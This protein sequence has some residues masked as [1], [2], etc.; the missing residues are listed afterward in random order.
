M[1]R[2]MSSKNVVALLLSGI[3]VASMVPVSAFGLDEVPPSVGDD[4][5]SEIV[6]A[7]CPEPEFDEFSGGQAQS[8]RFIDGF[9]D[10]TLMELSELSGV[11]AYSAFGDVK[12]DYRA[13][14]SKVNGRKTYTYRVNPTDKDRLVSVNGVLEVGIDVSEHNNAPGGGAAR[15]INWQKVKADGITFAIIRCGYGSD[16][17]SQDDD[18]FASNYKGAKAAGLKVG[19]YLYSYAKKATG[20]NPS[21]A[22]EADHVLRVFRENGIEPSDLDLPVYYDLEDKGQLGLEKRV[23]GQMATV[24][25]DKLQARGYKVGIYA[26]LDWFNTM[27]TD[28]VFKLENMKAKGWS[29]W[30]ARYPYG[31]ATSGVEG[32]DVWQFTSIGLVSGT[33]KKYCDVNFMFSSNFPNGGSG[34]ASGGNSVPQWVKSGSTWYLRCN[35]KNLTG[36][37]KVGSYWYWMDSS[38]AMRTGWL[39]LGGTWYYLD[40]SGAMATGWKRVGGAWY[41]LNPGSGAMATG[42]KYVDGAWYW[43]DSSGAMRTGWLLLGGTWYY[44]DGS[45]AMATGWKRVGGAWYYLN[46]GSGAMATGWK[47]VDGAWY[48]MDSSGAMRTGWLLIDG[49][50]YYFS[51][52]GSMQANR[53]VGNYYLT[54]SGEMATNMW[55]GQYHVNASGWWDETR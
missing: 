22:S 25:C 35:G 51:P 55:I 36:W 19:V 43:M 41:Y 8:W 38:G 47:Y 1:V 28:S 9:S 52:S 16:L 10:T 14:W 20:A 7:A 39:L 5:P 13:T 30:V 34:S 44:L 54:A 31:Q 46:P 24:F 4:A 50:W 29:R 26:N 53:W 32:T 40:G 49:A 3:L 48:W 18:W 2:P 33:P 6:E 15:A 17:A 23:L 45:G 12:E 21:A 27:L 42:W 11:S 37:Q